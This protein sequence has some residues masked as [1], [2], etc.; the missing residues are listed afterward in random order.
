MKIDT[1][2]YKKRLLHPEDERSNPDWFRAAFAMRLLL[3]LLPP[4]LS[5]D[6]QGI[7]FP[8]IIG[9]G[10]IPPDG[11][12]WP[13]GFILP[14]GFKWNNEWNP[15]LNLFFDTDIP[16]WLTFPENWTPQDELPP[17]VI[18]TV[19]YQLP[20]TFRP[21]NPL[22]GALEADP[23]AS[24]PPDWSYGDPLPPG[25]RLKPGYE[26]IGA[27]TQKE[28]LPPGLFQNYIESVPEDY[29]PYNM[30]PAWALQTRSP[31]EKNPTMDAANPLS[32]P[33]AP[34]FG[35]IRRVNK[36]WHET[37]IQV[38]V[39]M[40]REFASGLIAGWDYTH[41][42]VNAL[43]M[44]TNR[45]LPLCAYLYAD[46]LQLYQINRTVSYFNL[47]NIAADYNNA[48]VEACQLWMHPY[49]SSGSGKI[50]CQRAYPISGQV[51]DYSKFTGDRS[52]IATW[53]L[54]NRLTM[55]MK[56]DLLTYIN[57]AFLIGDYVQLM[58]R[59][60]DH[61]FLDVD[62]AGN[63]LFSPQVYQ[64]VVPYVT[65]L[66]IRIFHDGQV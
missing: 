50:I 59:E 14:P 28:A 5:K 35:H 49:D 26:N 24:F 22:P 32:D 13:P 16:P 30:P 37:T 15:W 56:G 65:V 8:P 33:F 31:I 3:L 42:A 60:Y 27:T 58:T 23:G 9:E 2:K 21:R 57:N 43:T 20:P 46:T 25:I 64:D 4:Q 45:D 62:P 55:S 41:D 66:V 53:S 18:P 48:H 47:A 54:A 6:L 61:D 19:G 38:P 39:Y 29:E 51:S 10:A 40:W 17:G 1:R 44:W 34:A 52:T 7:A 63:K 11:T 36:Q 12:E